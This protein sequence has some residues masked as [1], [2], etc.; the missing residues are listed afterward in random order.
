MRMT[1]KMA[2]F[3]SWTSLAEQSDHGI[4]KKRQAGSTGGT[5]DK[6]QITSSAGGAS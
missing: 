3:T 1:L 6:A 4:L 5:S 2:S